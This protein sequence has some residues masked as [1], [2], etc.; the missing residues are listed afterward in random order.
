MSRE[1]VTLPDVEVL[2][3]TELALLCRVGSREVWVP[4]KHVGIADRTVRKPG[5]RGSLSIPTRLARELRLEDYA[6]PARGRAS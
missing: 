3:A 5:D 4:V 1:F 6:S 2:E